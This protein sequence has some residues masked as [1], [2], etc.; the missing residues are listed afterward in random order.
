MLDEGIVEI[1]VVGHKDAPGKQF[2]YPLGDIRK[3]GA[4]LDHA[5]VYAGEGRNVR[6]DGTLWVHQGFVGLDH[7]CPVVDMDGNFGNAASCRKAACSLDINDS[8]FH[9]SDKNM[10][11]SLANQM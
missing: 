4:V 11:I 1:D 10:L 3:Q 6:R 9:P 8:I 5:I 7:R 2:V